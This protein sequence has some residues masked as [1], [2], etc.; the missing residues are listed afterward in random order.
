[1]SKVNRLWALASKPASNQSIRLILGSNIT[2]PVITRWNA[3]HDGVSE[4]LDKD[5]GKLSEL[6]TMYKIEPFTSVER[7]FLCEYRLVMKIIA[8][9][10]DNLQSNCYYAFVLPTL[11][12]MKKEINDFLVN[13][14]IKMCKPLVEAIRDGFQKR[15]DRHLDFQSNQSISGLIATVT[16]P[17]FKLRRHDEIRTTENID[18]IQKF[19]FKAA[20]AISPSDDSL[21]NNFRPNNDGKKRN[22]EYNET[23]FNPFIF[24]FAPNSTIRTKISICTL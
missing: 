1:M 7:S 4:L 8:D 5:P 24:H 15:F 12:K 22:F 11:F 21:N 23:T 16:H 17:F 13:P 19:L 2:R 20:D 3:F 10:L 6:M 9:A 14:Q 18:K